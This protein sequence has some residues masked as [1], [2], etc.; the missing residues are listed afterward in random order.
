MSD[1]SNR[2]KDVVT[3]D[4]VLILAALAVLGLSILGI[5]IY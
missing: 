5:S 1:L 4:R 2:L 3:Y